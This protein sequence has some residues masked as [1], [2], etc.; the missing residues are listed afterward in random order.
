[1]VG[2][3]LRRIEDRERFPMQVAIGRLP[4][5]L[6]EEQRQVR[7]V[8][9]QQV[10]RPDVIGLIARQHGQPRV[11]QVVALVGDLRIM[12]GEG[13]ETR[14]HT[15]LQRRRVV[16][17][18]HDAERVGP[19]VAALHRQLGQRRAEVADHRHGA[20]VHEHVAGGGIPVRDVAAQRDPRVV[21]VAPPR[22]DLASDG[23]LPL[24]LPRTHEQEIRGNLVE[25]LEEERHGLRR[26]FLEGQ[27]ADVRVIEPQ[28]GAVTLERRVA[29]VEIEHRVVPQPDAVGLVGGVVRQTPEEREGASL[30][31]N[32][33]GHGVGQLQDERLHFVTQLVAAALQVLGQPDDSPVRG[34]PLAR[35][36]DRGTKGPSGIRGPG[37]GCARIRGE[38]DQVERD[39]VEIGVLCLQVGIAP[40][41]Q[42][43][44]GRMGV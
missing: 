13:L 9:V 40:T 43:V 15:P 27:D 21:E 3:A 37:G 30:I 5:V 20:V 25:R 2:R 16:V 10:H 17:P 24:P 28:M 14:A 42:P 32:V 35:G 8:R 44:D 12:G 39:V 6:R 36:G 19:E 31:Q 33:R 38:H 41:E 29:G 1:M 22:V 11:Q 18:Q 34:Q 7:V 26:R 23:S 4:R